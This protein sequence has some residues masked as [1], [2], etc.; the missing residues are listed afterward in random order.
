M[1]ID[2][3]NEHDAHG[4]GGHDGGHHEPPEVVDGRQRMAIWLF[5][6]G[7]AITLSAL[8]FTYLYLRGVNTGGHWMSMVGLPGPQT[9]GGHTYA[10]Y[11]NAS[12]LPSPQVVLTKP[13]SAGLNWFVSFLT[14]LSG[15]II[16]GAEKGL[17]ATKNAKNFSALAWLATAVVVVTVFFTLKQL[18]SIPSVFVAINDSQTMSY[19][20]Y[21]STMMVII[22][23]GLVHLAI[24]AF[25]GVGLA[26][27][28]ARGAIPGDKWFQARLVRLFWVWVGISAIIGSAVTTTINT[29]H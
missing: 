9:A 1:S 13:L 22:G 27:R 7:D 29:I 18:H 5:I 17:R 20:A 8:L 3:H 2:T 19:S 24:L 4:H 15:L 12:S 10:Y 26:I 23:S 14:L 6:S 11:E 21:A 28:S 16:W 25:L